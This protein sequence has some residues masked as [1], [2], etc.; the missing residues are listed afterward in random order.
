MATRITFNR[1]VQDSP[2]FGSTETQ[3]VSR[4]YLE[5]EH[6]GTVYQDLFVDIWEAVGSTHGDE[7]LSIGALQG[8]PALGTLDGDALEEA[9]RSYYQRLVNSAGYGKHLAK[10]KGFRTQGDELGM[11][12][13]VEL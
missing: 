11:V 8:S 3:S 5:L 13:S 1:V 2:E 7:E 9:V 4:V 12:Q 6:G 10:D